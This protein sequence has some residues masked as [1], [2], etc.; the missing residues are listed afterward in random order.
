MGGWCFFSVMF[1]VVNEIVLFSLN[2]YIARPMAWC[3]RDLL[4]V[5]TI[6]E[7]VFVVHCV[8][9]VSVAIHAIRVL[10]AANDSGMSTSLDLAVQS[11][12]E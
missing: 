11:Y 8:E 7:L 1:E 3:I 4:C 6:E 2:F 5:C 9:T 12:S 10:I